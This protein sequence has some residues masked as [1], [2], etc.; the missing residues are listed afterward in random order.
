M[1]DLNLP[2]QRFAAYLTDRGVP[3]HRIIAFAGLSTLAVVDASCRPTRGETGVAKGLCGYYHVIESLPPEVAP[4]AYGYYWYKRFGSGQH[5]AWRAAFQFEYEMLRSLAP[6]DNWAQVW[7]GEMEG[8]IP[9]YVMRHYKRGSLAAHGAAEGWNLPAD[10]VLRLSKDIATALAA[11]HSVGVVHR[12]L[13]AE[14]VLLTDDGGAAVADLGCAR[15]LSAPPTQPRRR[16]DEFHW[17]PEYAEAY[18]VAG[19]EADVYSLGV[20]MYQ[21]TVGRMPRHGA[22]PAHCAPRVGR[23]P[24][25][26]ITLADACVAYEPKDRPQSVKEILAD[27]ATA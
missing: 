8:E 24:A 17:P 6:H 1:V 13:N 27:L 14:N 3:V 22:P 21:M 20:L 16:A 19:V 9:Y 25:A 4:G 10:R 15:R 12:D 23:F 5:D 7:W 18:D 2:T 11:L 26:L